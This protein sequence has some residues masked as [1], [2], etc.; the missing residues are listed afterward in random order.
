MTDVPWWGVPL[1][2]G[3]FAFVGVLLAQGV[4][5]YSERRKT[6]REDERRWH[7]ERRVVYAAFT[8]GLRISLDSLINRFENKDGDKGT[9]D[10]LNSPADPPDLKSQIDEVELLA[11]KEV[12]DAASSALR[13]I[14]AMQA[15]LLSLN[16]SQFNSAL[17]SAERR[18]NEFVK[19]ARIEL[20]IARPVKRFQ[21]SADSI[22]GIMGGVFKEMW[23][24]LTVVLVGS[25]NSRATD[26]NFDSSIHAANE[27]REGEKT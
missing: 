3:A 6:K 1:V 2:S 27:E 23:R 17:E 15:R 16:E 4:G 7:A 19:V 14:V 18:R 21:V 10:Y 25:R 20:G 5:L 8:R 22:F 11:T 9:L 26:I 24:T 12:A 13:V